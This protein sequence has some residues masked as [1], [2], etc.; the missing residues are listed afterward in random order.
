MTNL[1]ANFFR[2]RFFAFC[3][4]CDQTG[5]ATERHDTCRSE[6]P[7]GSIPRCPG[8]ARGRA[9]CVF[10]KIPGEQRTT[11]PRVRAGTSGRGQRCLQEPPYDASGKT[12]RSACH[13]K[14]NLQ[15]GLSHSLFDVYICR[16]DRD[17]CGQITYQFFHQQKKSTY[18]IL[19]KNGGGGR[20][21]NDSIHNYRS[22]TE[23]CAP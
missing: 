9:E 19:A 11:A 12:S 5:R 23:T 13:A 17:G 6:I 1:M 7:E 20:V 14:H 16:S 10:C 2:R 8:N 3:S 18:G 22:R 4:C 15:G 21:K